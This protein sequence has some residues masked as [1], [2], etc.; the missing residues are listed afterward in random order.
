MNWKRELKMNKIIL[1]DI[2]LGFYEEILISRFNSNIDK[3]NSEPTVNDNVKFLVNENEEILKTLELLDTL[4]EDIF[5]N[6]FTSY[7]STV[8]SR[9][10]NP[11]IARN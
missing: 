8:P 9:L 1:E 10:S 2:N 5:L 11:A 7:K 6:D 4:N 3:I